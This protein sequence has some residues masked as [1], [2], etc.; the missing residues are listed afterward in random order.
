MASGWCS[1]VFSHDG[2]PLLL[3]EKEDLRQVVCK[4]TAKL[5]WLSGVDFFPQGREV[6]EFRGASFLCFLASAT[7][8]HQ[9]AGYGSDGGRPRAADEASER[10]RSL[11]SR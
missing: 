5:M 11:L 10:W 3:K 2:M 1:A 9:R 4:L 7:H 8:A 6:A